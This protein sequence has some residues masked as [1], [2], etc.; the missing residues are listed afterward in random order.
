MNHFH[1]LHISIFFWWY[2]PKSSTIFNHRKYKKWKNRDRKY[3]QKACQVLILRYIY[4]KR[5][6]GTD[7][8]R[9]RP[10]PKASA[11]VS[12]QPHSTFICQPV[13]LNGIRNVIMSSVS[14]CSPTLKIVFSFDRCGSQVGIKKCEK[15]IKILLALIIFYKMN[16]D[17]D[18]LLKL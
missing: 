9:A 2:R 12:V 13:S 3:V 14:F 8:S 17:N 6:N 18:A 10:K 1:A 15:L 16:T 7:S 4:T 11:L 5:I